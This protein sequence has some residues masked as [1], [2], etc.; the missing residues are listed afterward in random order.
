MKVVP[1]PVIYSPPA[2]APREPKVEG[3]ESDMDSTKPER[4]S[5]PVYDTEEEAFL[6][7]LGMPPPQNGKGKISS[8]LLHPP[9]PINPYK[10]PSI[11]QTMIEIPEYIESPETIEYLGV[12]PELAQEIWGWDQ[13]L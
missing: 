10:P 9:D 8:T 7:S 12:N 3:Y 13:F 6:T 2:P 5:C 1:Y 11:S 4:L